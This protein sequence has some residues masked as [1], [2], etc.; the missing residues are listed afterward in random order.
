MENSNNNHS[1]PLP[2]VPTQIICLQDAIAYIKALATRL[3]EAGAKSILPLDLLEREAQ[4]LEDAL[5][6]YPE[7][8]VGGVPAVFL[9]YSSKELQLDADGLEFV[10]ETDALPV[11]EQAGN[12]CG[13]GGVAEGKGGG[14][15][16][17]QGGGRRKS[18]VPECIEVE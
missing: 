8:N 14:A 2:F 10:V 7:G 4:A 9:K 3:D 16:N 6:K 13:S 18:A 17:S 11:D 12:G 15:R 1:F 5:S